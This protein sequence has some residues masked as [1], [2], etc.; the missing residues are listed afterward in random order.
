M[1]DKIRE[2][3]KEDIEKEG[4]EIVEVKCSK[5]QGRTSIKIFIDKPGGVA[6]DD[7]E[8]ASGIISF[9]LDG[10]NLNLAGYELEVSSPGLDRPLVSERDFEKCLGKTVMINLK[11]SIND[12]KNYIEGKIILV[13][14]NNI[15]VQNK[16]REAVIPIETIS[17]AKLKIEIG[18]Q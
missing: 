12:I 16:N 10:S 2:I 7:C 17:K 14:Q 9:L 3:I 1:E 8:K 6:I 11:E 13:D 18:G 15:T 5:F 4:F